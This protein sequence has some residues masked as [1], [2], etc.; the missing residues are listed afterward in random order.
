MHRLG[1]AIY[2]H[3]VWRDDIL[4]DVDGNVGAEVDDYIMVVFNSNGTRTTYGYDV[5]HDEL[6]V[7]AN[8]AAGT[9][10]D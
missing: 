1:L 9:T 4:Q 3:M 7:S 6:Y 10:D 2:P 5:Q 8:H